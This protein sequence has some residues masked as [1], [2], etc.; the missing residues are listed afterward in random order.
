MNH[1]QPRQQTEP[2]NQ[3]LEQ[4]L[5]AIVVECVSRTHAELQ[6]GFRIVGEFF[7]SNGALDYRLWESQ[8]DVGI[9]VFVIDDEVK[10]VGETKLTMGLERRIYGYK[11]PDPSQ[12]TN[13]RVN[14]LLM[15]EL[16]KRKKPQIWF[17]RMQHLETEIIR[18]LQPEWNKTLKY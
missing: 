4:R 8:G 6:V 17:F 18:R 14:S 15:Q 11:K 5:D 2:P 16:R 9:Y 1:R 7:E 3:S 10:Y 13:Q 12:K